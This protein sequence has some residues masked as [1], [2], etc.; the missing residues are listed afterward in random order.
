MIKFP[1]FWYE[2][3]LYFNY[4][5][6][7][8]DLQKLFNNYKGSESVDDLLD[9]SKN[10]PQSKDDYYGLRRECNGTKTLRKFLIENGINATICGS[11]PIVNY[12]INL[13]K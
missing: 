7:I 12:C 13:S 6:S 10:N 11:I 4:V 8:E 3:N 2:G 1:K 5:S 9:K